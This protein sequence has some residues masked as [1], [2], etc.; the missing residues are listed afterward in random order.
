MRKE[1]KELVMTKDTQP[2]NLIGS[3]W[4][5][6]E[7][8]EDGTVFV[9]VFSEGKYRGA[10]MTLILNGDTG[11]SDVDGSAATPAIRGTDS[12]TGIFFP[13]A[14]TIAFAEG[15]VE[16]ARFDSSGRL[17]V[18]S[19]SARANLFNSTTTASLQIEGTTA[20]TSAVLAV[21]DTD[22]AAA[23]PFFILARARGTT[24]GSTT[25]VQSG[26]VAGSISFQASDGTEFVETARI[27]SIVDGTPGANDMPGALLFSTTTDG[28]SSSTERMRIDSSGNL[29]FNSG[30]G[31]VATAYGCRA[32]VNF[33]GTGTVA[34]RAS[35]NVTSITDNGVG[36]YL[37]N[38]TTALPD[39]NASV[40]IGLGADSGSSGTG[41]WASRINSIS[42][43][44]IQILSARP[45]GSY[46]DASIACV[47]VHR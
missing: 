39:S 11:L 37:I 47:S 33:N 27:Q 38:L 35:G 36:N 6:I 28:G 2:V 5:E 34:I 19:T 17:L 18:N 21:R 25:V 13:A 3:E 32:W 20:D 15:G 40:T 12:N 8:L 41:A 26:D 31:S 44:V 4:H 1:G 42:T 10:T 43:T 14:D 24:V 22:T 46:S 45:D 29:Q 30:Y 9:N 7:A 23:G 16:S